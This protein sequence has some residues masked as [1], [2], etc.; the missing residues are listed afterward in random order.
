MSEKAKKLKNTLPEFKAIAKKEA[1]AP[2]VRYYEGKEGVW[3]IL[4]D[5][6]N[7][8][9]ETW[10]IVPG[11][12]YDVFGVNRM[13]KEVID[14]RRQMQKKAHMIA[15]HH[16]EEIR[17]WRLEE[18]DIREYRFLPELKDLDTAV[19]LYGNKVALLFLKEP[20]NGLIIENKELFKVFKFMFDSLWKELEGKNLPDAD[21]IDEERKIQLK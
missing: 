2:S 19:F 5:L 13:M 3:N 12:V 10:L 11:K 9:S 4:D 8:K 14:K 1:S 7:S 16:L 20:F 18:T 15:D 6:I 17:L 21:A